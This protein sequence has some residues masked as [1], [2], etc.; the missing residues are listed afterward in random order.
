MDRERAALADPNV[1]ADRLIG[2]WQVL[3]RERQALRGWRHDEA[4]GKVEGQMRQVASA[5]EH[6][7]QVEAIVRTR[8]KELGIAS[9]QRDRSI[10]LQMERE[11]TR[12][13]GIGL[14]R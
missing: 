14:K 12:V 7:P 5:I 9:P 8:A 3:D 10:A 1:R 13:R 2:H 6:D 11:L 4:R